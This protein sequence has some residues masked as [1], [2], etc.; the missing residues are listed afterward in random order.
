MSLVNFNTTSLHFSLSSLIK[1]LTMRFGRILLNC[2]DSISFLHS[3]ISRSCLMTVSVRALILAS[4][5]AN[6]FCTLFN[7]PLTCVT[8]ACTTP[9]FFVKSSFNSLRSSAL[10]SAID[11]L[12]LLYTLRI[13]S[14]RLRSF[15]SAS[16]SDPWFPVV[17]SFNFGSAISGDS[18]SVL[19]RG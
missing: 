1:P 16:F 18:E 6:L 4:Q 3:W 19:I 8:S 2:R 9:I 11:F 10:L 17:T 7:S 15:S 14:R 13:K 5:F 12:R